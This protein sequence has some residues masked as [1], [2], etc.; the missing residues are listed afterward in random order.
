MALCEDAEGCEPKKINCRDQS[1]SS[2]SYGKPLDSL[3]ALLKDA[4]IDSFTAQKIKDIF[5]ELEN[6]ESIQTQ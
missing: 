6:K 5:S 2:N 4:Q 1:P 3:K